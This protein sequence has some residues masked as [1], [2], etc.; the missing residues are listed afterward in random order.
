M[1]WT[2]LVDASEKAARI[3]AVVV[4]GS[5][6]Y[7]NALRGRTFIPRLQLEL[8][9]KI[10]CDSGKR[11]LL[12]TMQVKN[13]GSSIVRV[14]Q[15]GTCLK[16]TPLLGNNEGSGDNN[17][18]RQV[19]KPLPVLKRYLVS[20]RKTIVTDVQEI[21]P[22]AAIN[23]QQLIPITDE[24]TRDFE[25]ELRINVIRGAWWLPVKWVPEA[26]KDKKWWVPGRWI[27][28][29]KFSAIAIPVW[30]NAKELDKDA[31]GLLKEKTE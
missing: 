10:F 21:E 12:V 15:D 1:D 14:T 18:K 5:W 27:I 4:A 20:S 26:R 28:I 22:S 25:L 29:R 6:V 11:Y 7:F 13:V 30:V 19:T 8:S 2:Q 31:A 17:L 9:G 16:V 23:E 24:R 3:V